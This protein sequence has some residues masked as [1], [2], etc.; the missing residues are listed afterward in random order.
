MGLTPM[1]ASHKYAKVE[2]VMIELGGKMLNL[3]AIEIEKSKEE[4]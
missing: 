1:N 4:P 3:E 2:R